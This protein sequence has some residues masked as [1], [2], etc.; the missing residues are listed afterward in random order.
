MEKDTPYTAT[1]LEVEC[2]ILHVRIKYQNAGKQAFRH[3]NIF[4]KLTVS[5]RQW[6]SGIRVSP[7]PLV[8]DE[9]GIDQQC[10]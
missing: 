8:T 9:S 3:R 10:R 6:H 1:L 2:N 7:V 5:V 4:R